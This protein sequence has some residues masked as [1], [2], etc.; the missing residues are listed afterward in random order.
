MTDSL[1]NVAAQQRMTPDDYAVT[2][3]AGDFAER[4]PLAFE[5]F[6]SGYYAESIRI[7]RDA[8]L[9]DCTAGHGDPCATCEAI[10]AGLTGIHAEQRATDPKAAS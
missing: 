3:I 2:A 6:L 1:V 4:G 7:I 8:H 9:T 10:R 5:S